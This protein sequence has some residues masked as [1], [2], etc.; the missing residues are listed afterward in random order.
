KVALV[1]ATGSGKSTLVRLLVR[2]HDV[3][4]GRITMDGVDIREIPQKIYRR[5]F[6]TVLQDVFLF[7]GNVAENIALFDASIPQDPIEAAARAVQ[8]D[9]VIGRLKDG[10]STKVLERGS[11]FSQGERQLLSFARALAH[12]PE[13]LVLDE[14]TASV[15]SVTEAKIQKAL[16][17]LF[18]GR[19][20]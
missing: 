11:N 16:D 17:A 1:G 18:E 7:T 2:Q 5:S 6:A 20:A 3:R 19:T 12:D 9:E 13:I 15:D 10:Y 8:A 4:D 14:A